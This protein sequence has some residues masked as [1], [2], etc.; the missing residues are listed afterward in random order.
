MQLTVVRHTPR[1][2]VLRLKP[3]HLAAYW[4]FGLLFVAMGLGTAWLLGRA[5]SFGCERDAGVTGT[6]TYATTAALRTTR[7][8]FPVSALHGADVR[9]SGGGLVRSKVLVLRTDGG[10]LPLPL[11]NANGA[12]KDSLAA[13][14]AAFVQGAAPAV[15]VREDSRALGFLFGLFLVGAGVVCIGVIE[16][17]VLDMDRDTGRVRIRGLRHGRLRRVDIPLD[18]VRGVGK[19]AFTVRRARSWSVYLD[20]GDRAR[21]PLTRAA[22]CT[23]RSAEQTVDVIQSWLAETPR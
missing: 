5:V 9:L 21:E 8:T 15:R 11:S 16:R 18:L 10:D 4:G 7:R 22:L 1:R 23:D 13:L 17:F 20:L 14:I 3:V 6:C 19:T 12:V 2:L